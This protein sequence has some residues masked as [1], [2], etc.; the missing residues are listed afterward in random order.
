MDIEI[1]ARSADEF[2]HPFEARLHLAAFDTRDQGL[3]DPRELSEPFLGKP[4]SPP[5]LPNDLPCIHE[6]QYTSTASV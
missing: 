1:E 4:R 5:G 2:D 6:R 3:G